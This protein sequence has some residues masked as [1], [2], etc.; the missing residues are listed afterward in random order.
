[1]HKHTTV[2]FELAGDVNGT[3]FRI[4]GDGHGSPETGELEMDLELSEI[5]EGWD[6]KTFPSICCHATTAYFCAADEAVPQFAELIDS[7]YQVSP[8][9]QA[10]IVDEAGEKKAKF[11]ATSE[12]T[13]EDDTL[14][15][16]NQLEGESD[17][18]EIDRLCSPI[19]DVI[20]PNGPGRITTLTTYTLETVDGERLQG[21]T[22]VP[23]QLDTDVCLE[24]PIHRTI[25]RVNTDVVGQNM[26]TEFAA[27]WHEPTHSAHPE[28]MIDAGSKPV[29]ESDD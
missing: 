13:V 21:T 6:P 14:V 23:Y 28:P 7:E 29:V 18:P 26:T 15:S 9:R 8:A 24:S 5:P 22:T 19:Q 10:V 2:D 27:N 20:L 11:S 12:V 4:F 1:M 17:L 3:E 25:S 16:R